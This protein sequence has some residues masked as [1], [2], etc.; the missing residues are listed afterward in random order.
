MRPTRILTAIF[1]GLFPLIGIVLLVVSFFVYR[2]HAR[3]RETGVLTT[4]N[5]V[6]MTERP[7]NDGDDEDDGPM[8]APII[9]FTTTK[10]EVV[11]FTS[12]TW[13][14]PPEYEPGEAVQILYQPADPS[15]AEIESAFHR[16][17]SAAILGGT[18]LVLAAVG[19]IVAFVV[20]KFLSFEMP[21]AAP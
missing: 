4:G 11:E 13:S 18:G 2:S 1:G 6:G 14:R 19:A 7:D 17:G 20:S 9:R 5:V 8:Y 15:R 16:Y 10:G 21:E 3:E 12:S